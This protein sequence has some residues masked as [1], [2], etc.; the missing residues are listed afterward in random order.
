MSASQWELR[1]VVIDKADRS[2]FLAQLSS[3]SGTVRLCCGDCCSGDS[4]HS[5]LPVVLVPTKLP[6]FVH[7]WCWIFI[8]LALRER[9]QFMLPSNSPVAMFSIL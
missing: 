2:G 7:L 9:I 1:V 5:F 6:P 3:T 4:S 8:V